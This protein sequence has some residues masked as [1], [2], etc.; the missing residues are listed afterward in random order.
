MKQ[1]VFEDSIILY[2]EKEWE[3]K[4]SPDYSVYLDGVL[5]CTTGKTHAT[6]RGLMPDRDYSVRIDRSFKG[7]T[8]PILD[9][10]LHTPAARR[11][12]DVTLP[13]YSAVGDGRTVNT[14]ALQA[15][16][17]DCRD[18][19]TVYLP[20][21]V[22]LTGALDLHSD[23]ELYLE[24]GAILQG[25]TD[26]SAY[27]P[28][29]RSRFE[30]WEMDCY[31]ALLNIGK[32]DS[33]GGYTCGNVILRGDGSI[34][35]G[36]RELSDNITAAERT[37]LTASGTFTDKECDAIAP[38]ARGRLIQICNTDGVTIDGLALG[39]GAAWNV[40]FVYS[41]NVI[42]CNGS[43]TSDGVPNGDGWDPDSSEDST[44]FHM[45]FNTGDDGIAIKSGKN[46]EGNRIGRPTRGIRIFDC[47][48]KDGIAIGSE[49]SGGVED[50]AI[51]DC[52]M[53]H[54]RSRRGF[55]I[56]TTR[57]RGGYVRHIRV[58]DSKFAQITIYTLYGCND[59][60]DSA[61]GQEL[62]EISDVS[63][64][65]V[66]ASGKLANWGDKPGY[67]PNAL[68]I[69]VC[70]FDEQYIQGLRMEDITVGVPRDLLEKRVTI[71]KTDGLILENL[72]TTKD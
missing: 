42:T 71:E 51:W 45:E 52:V 18:G 49:L 40:H 44:V 11:R 72:T 20:S 55:R 30:G 50:V 10:V 53:Q 2:W 69:Q 6:M 38:R 15:A 59:D 37:I 5:F 58:K 8:S 46:P 3:T 68:C 48:G 36:G 17:D 23:M 39:Y 56:K 67:I 63:L 32:M 57:K 61:D 64:V 14:R 12:I 66:E 4:G 29:V 54:E 9:T 41:R 21:G 31:R 60:G 19:E 34:L 16:I 35:G 7:E 65:G 43:I 27:L 13:P 70:G 1:I 22:Y 47:H 28:K 33:A 26:A 25:V 62:T 24:S